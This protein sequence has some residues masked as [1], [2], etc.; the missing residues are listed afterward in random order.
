YIKCGTDTRSLPEG[1]SPL[2]VTLD[3]AVELFK[4]PKTRGRAAPKEPIKTFEASPVTGNPVKLLEGR[5][6]PYVADG[7]TNASLPK[8][9]D[10]ASLS[11]EAALDLLAERAA[12]GPSV[13]K[14]SRKKA[15][16][17]AKKTGE[18]TKK[19]ATK[20][21]AKK[22]TAAKKTTKTLKKGVAKKK[23]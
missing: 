8:G 11:F 2:E 20:K 21:T 23:S 1:V 22:K 9:V 19:K 18:G 3:E 5:F 6:G 7:T 16:K 17:A 4:Q 14:S 12:R 15:A 10:P 13:K